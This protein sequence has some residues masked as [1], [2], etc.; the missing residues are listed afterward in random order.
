MSKRN[1]LYIIALAILGA[2]VLFIA[3]R[4]SVDRR[5]PPMN[6]PAAPGPQSPSGPTVRGPDPAP[7][8]STPEGAPSDAVAPAKEKT[9]WT[10]IPPAIKFAC[11]GL[12][13]SKL[14]PG[15]GYEY[16]CL[17]IYGQTQLLGM[18]Q[19]E[20]GTLRAQVR[21]LQKLDFAIMNW[22][23]I[24]T[25][26]EHSFNEI[27]I[28]DA[29]V[30][31]NLLRQLVDVVTSDANDDL[32]TNLASGLDL[33]F[34]WTGDALKTR[35]LVL[36]GELD[37]DHVALAAVRPLLDSKN[38]E[39]VSAAGVVLAKSGSLGEVAGR[40]ESVGPEAQAAFLAAFKWG[41]RGG[42]AIEF[43][44][45]KS[46]GF[47]TNDPRM[48]E[49]AIFLPLVRSL[50]ESTRDERVRAAALDV[51]TQ[52]WGEAGVLDTLRQALVSRDNPEV[53]SALLWN[54][55]SYF[56]A[57]D[58]GAAARLMQLSARGNDGL[59][60]AA[61]HRLCASSD[62]AVVQFLIDQFRGA[63][64][65]KLNAALSALSINGHILREPCLRALESRLPDMTD[66]EMRET[67]TRTIRAMRN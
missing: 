36:L 6:P 17:D 26:T 35:A 37:P 61:T 27:E 3:P 66:P 2:A 7:G 63:T 52:F 53:L 1:F 21:G 30:R 60:V 41:Q 31:S 4:R 67:A 54:R 55:Q 25:P 16:L 49:T 65:A 13:S 12:F 58:A 39:H 57:R 22:A 62:P 8:A 45:G 32:A 10:K 23:G 59:A 48:T 40:I 9:P 24:P 29:D 46:F 56:F 20:A 50:A 38:P 15:T 33:P 43:A 44:G 42:G 19:E 64:G 18:P 34:E 28:P 11:A 47:A 14:G 5:G 51:L